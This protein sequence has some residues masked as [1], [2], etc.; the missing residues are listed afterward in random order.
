MDGGHDEKQFHFKVA[1]RETG[2][3]ETQPI[4]GHVLPLRRLRTWIRRGL[5]PTLAILL[6]G[7]LALLV[8]L[9]P[10]PPNDEPS[11]SLAA[12]PL[13]REA[14]AEPLVSPKEPTPKRSHGPSD[15]KNRKHRRILLAQPKRRNVNIR[16]AAAPV[17][18]APAPEPVRDRSD[19]KKD[20]KKTS[21]P[22][23][24]L[25]LRRLYKD[26]NGDHFHSV[27]NEAV[28]E[29][30]EKGYELK[31]SIGYLFEKQV[32]GTTLLAIDEGVMGW[33]YAK[34]QGKSTRPLYRLVGPEY[35]D[36]E[37]ILTSSEHKKT[38]WIG[39]GWRVEKIMGYVG[40]P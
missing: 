23:P 31:E 21:Q 3:P 2:L 38:Y 30:Q 11:Q 22:R 4:R 39:N 9:I 12:V 16:A 36:Y 24:T 10:T 8:A 26:K 13:E 7:T 37:V 32:K 27:F 20:D 18:S 25:L 1:D 40:R 17:G 34:D 5:L 19:R 28:T 14:R 6:V 33:I 15:R 35:H 29:K